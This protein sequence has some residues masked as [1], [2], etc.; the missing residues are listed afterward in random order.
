MHKRIII[1]FCLIATGFSSFS[2]VPISMSEVDTETYGLWLTKDWDGL[3]KKGKNAINQGIDFYYLRVR[4]G[5]AYYEK[6]N[7]H[8]AVKHF[9]TAYAA[10]PG[11][12]YLKEY[13]YFAYL[14]SGREPEALRLASSFPEDLKV[15]V[16]ANINKF[17]DYFD[18]Y[19]GRNFL[20]DPAVAGNYSIDIDPQIDGSQIISKG[21]DLISIGLSHRI[22]PAFSI[23]QR[24][25]GL[26]KTNFVY[27]QKDGLAGTKPDQKTTLHQYYIS[28]NVRM[29]KNLALS[30]GLH[31]INIR[32]PLETV[33]F[34]QGRNWV[35]TITISKNDFVGFVS[36]YRQFSYFTIGG[37]FYYAGL[38]NAEQYQ[39]DVSLILYPFGN[40]NFYAI[41][42]LSHQSEEDHIEG[43][44]NRI[45]FN[46]ELGVRLT[47]KIWAEGYGSF[48]ELHNFIGAGGEAIFNSLDIIR[49]RYGGRLVVSPNRKLGFR[50]DYTWVENESTYI[51]G[52]AEITYNRNKIKYVNHSITGGITLNL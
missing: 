8:M 51:P 14:F 35:K 29:A 23:D 17:I 27:Y 30:G 41:S 2:Q 9:E 42:V 33:V 37:A 28:G 5:I 10:N 46:Q 24:Y 26:S 44:R 31:Y 19:Y 50:I 43:L 3:I 39:K 6:N 4:M 22:G 16:G 48:G 25:T 12:I 1:A 15:K 52:S 38:N 40:L 20:D 21:Y 49:K 11:E 34:S 36:L 7:Y 32:Y 47:D 18:V 13:L 45:V